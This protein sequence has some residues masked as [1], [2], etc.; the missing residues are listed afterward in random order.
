[1]DAPS[2]STAST[3]PCPQCAGQLRAIAVTDDAWIQ[4]LFA[5][6]AKGGVVIIERT[7]DMVI[8]GGAP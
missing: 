4:Y 2:P 1:M 3:A 6:L 7:G 5:A 8:Y